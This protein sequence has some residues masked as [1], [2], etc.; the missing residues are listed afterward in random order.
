MP[1]ISAPAPQ[2]LH[3]PPL[4]ARQ[5]PRGAQAAALLAVALGAGLLTVPQPAQ[6]APAAQLRV[7][8]VQGDTRLS[9]YD[10]ERVTD[11]PGVVT[12]VRAFGSSRGFW[13]Q[14]PEPDRNPATS[15]G[16]FVYTGRTTPDVAP[17]DSVLASGTVSEY[18]PGGKSADLQS[19]TELTDASWTAAGSAEP[20]PAAFRLR[21]ATLPNRYAP[22]APDGG[23]IE[24]LPLRP[25]GY[26]LDRYESLEGMRVQV[27]DARV[28]GATSSYNE[29]WVT[30]DPHENRTARGGT[31]YGSYD[32]QNGG[33][34]KVASLI[35]FAERPFPDA[36]V[37]DRLAGTTAGPLDYDQFGGYELQ[38]T[39]LGELRDNG[40]ERETTRAQRADELSVA[41]TTWRTSP[42]GTGRPSSPGSPRPWSAIS[43]RPTSSPWRRSRTPTAPPTTPS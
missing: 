30:A 41:R 16:I 15:E 40:L 4:P 3:R 1:P 39:E 31:L 43:P 33:R 27:S 11:L 29:L 21:P 19:I 6:A 2:P 36:N 42:P 34:V 20:L 35:P 18:Y 23:D 13:L 17:G 9:P 10:G 37:G 28:T 8:D 12:A 38:A 32:D 14:D 24:S 22:E 7:H 25:R 26:A 5:R